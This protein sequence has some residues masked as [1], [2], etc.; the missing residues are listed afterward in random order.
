MIYRPISRDNF[1]YSICLMVKDKRMIILYAMISCNQPLFTIYFSVW[2]ILRVFYSP[3]HSL[4]IPFTL[5]FT[6]SLSILFTLSLSLS[7]KFSLF[8]RLSYLSLPLYISPSI[9]LSLSLL[10]SLYLYHSL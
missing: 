5:P 10:H 6:L 1:V 7:L 4:S 2:E 8:L 3:F 9:F